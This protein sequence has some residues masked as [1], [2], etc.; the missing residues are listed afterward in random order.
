MLPEFSAARRFDAIAALYT[1]MT[2]V[3]LGWREK[4]IKKVAAVIGLA[5]VAFVDTGRCPAAIPEAFETFLD[6]L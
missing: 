2:L 3:Q 6:S 1:S 5:P 4:T